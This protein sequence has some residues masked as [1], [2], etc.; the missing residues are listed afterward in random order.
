[1]CEYLQ[2]FYLNACLCVSER[3]VCECITKDYLQGYSD[4][5]LHAVPAAVTDLKINKR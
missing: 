1:M 4:T 3:D 2:E 5:V